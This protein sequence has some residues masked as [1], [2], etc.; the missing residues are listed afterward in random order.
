MA[1]R[2]AWAVV[3]MSQ[4]HMQDLQND[5]PAAFRSPNFDMPIRSA[6][7]LDAESFFPHR[8][9]FSGVSG[10]FFIASFFGGENGKD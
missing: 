10:F 9:P 2:A 5:I 4:Y 8:T 1:D 7:R 3:V 6:E